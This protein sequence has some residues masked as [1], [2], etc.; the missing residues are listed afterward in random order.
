MKRFAAAAL[1]GA[2]LAAATPAL[3]S[4]RPPWDNAVP[5]VDLSLFEEGANLAGIA[6]REFPWPD[7][8]VEWISKRP[9]RPGSITTGTVVLWA[10]A[11]PD[12]EV[13]ISWRIDTRSWPGYP[14]G[15]C[16]VRRGERTSVTA[17][18]GGECQ[19]LRDGAP[20]PSPLLR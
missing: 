15:R 12:F 16:M 20:A 8:E 9:A 17:L 6:N 4:V 5:R 13:R 18:P 3:G 2:L 1:A 10:E 14:E 11:G 19:D 7:Q